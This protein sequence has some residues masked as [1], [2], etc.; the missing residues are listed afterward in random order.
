MCCINVK[1]VA[2]VIE[3]TVNLKLVAVKSVCSGKPVANLFINKVGADSVIVG[4]IAEGSNSLIG[5]LS[6]LPCCAAASS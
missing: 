2:C 1:Y 3:C 6:T 5:W 4:I